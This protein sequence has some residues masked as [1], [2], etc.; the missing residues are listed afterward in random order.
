MPH[1][2]LTNVV[3]KVHENFVLC[4][5]DFIFYVPVVQFTSNVRL[6]EFRPWDILKTEF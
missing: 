4:F 5:P 6:Q 3:T 2:N 1:S